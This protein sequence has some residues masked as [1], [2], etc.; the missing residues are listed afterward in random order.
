MKLLG[1]KKREAEWQAER[2]LG[3]NEQVGYR[4]GGSSLPMT[5]LS[6][7]LGENFCMNSLGKLYGS[8]TGE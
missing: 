5:V 3:F 2:S 6:P 4:K 1:I 8:Q 7:T